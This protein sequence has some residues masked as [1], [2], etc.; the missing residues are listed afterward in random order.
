VITTYDFAS[1]T[2]GHASTLIGGLAVFDVATGK[3][4]DPGNDTPEVEAAIKTVQRER[5]RVF[6]ETG[7]RV[8]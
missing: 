6:G 2:F 4:I 1:K 7:R 8:E 3:C 5:R